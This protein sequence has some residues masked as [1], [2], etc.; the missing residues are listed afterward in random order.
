M[1]VTDVAPV[2]VPHP[3]Q[4]RDFLLALTGRDVEVGRAHPVV[5]RDPAVVA[6]Y[7]SD[8]LATGAIAACD[9]PFAAYVGGA[10][11]LVPPPLVDQEVMDGQLSAE[12]TENVGEVLS[13]LGSVFNALEEAPHLKLHKVHPV[14]EKLP[15]DVAAMLGYVVRRVDLQIALHGYGA[16][17]LS[18]VSVG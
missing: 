8:R 3:K 5:A 11:G 18:V 15:S 17:W 13:V 12:L 7:V 4:I 2:P 16:G 6:V 1:A 14:G 9:L 10:L